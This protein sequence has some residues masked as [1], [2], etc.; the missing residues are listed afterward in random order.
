M[1]SSPW[2]SMEYKETLLT[3]NIMSG[4]KL[5]HIAQFVRYVGQIPRLSKHQMPVA[6]V[7]ISRQKS[8]AFSNA[9]MIYKSI[10]C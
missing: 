1:M 2:L 9:N 8:L 3:K 4:R 7:T 5:R 6:I 10:D